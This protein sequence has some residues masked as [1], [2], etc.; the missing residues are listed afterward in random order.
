MGT[1][2]GARTGRERGRGRACRPVDE[3]GVQRLG[4]AGIRRFRPR[5]G[6]QNRPFRGYDNITPYM[7][8]KLAPNSSHLTTG[9]VKS[10]SGRGCFRAVFSR[11]GDKS[12]TSP[13]SPNR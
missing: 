11:N 13:P 3:R 4:R 1:G 5:G 10:V 12:V 7:V 9:L 6:H 2:T 8:D